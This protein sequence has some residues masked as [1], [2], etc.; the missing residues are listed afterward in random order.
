[1]PIPIQQLSSLSLTQL[2]NI[3]DNLARNSF[4]LTNPSGAE[5][6]LYLDAI[7]DASALDEGSAVFVHDGANYRLSFRINGVVRSVLLT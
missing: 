4:K 5:G 7:P 1:M 2:K 3:T 6:V